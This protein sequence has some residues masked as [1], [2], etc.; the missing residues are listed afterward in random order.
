[1]LDVVFQPGNLLLGQLGGGLAKL[2]GKLAAGVGQRP[3]GLGGLSGGVG[4][5]PLPCPLAGLVHLLCGQ[6]G[7]LGGLLGLQ[8]RKLRAKA[9]PFPRAIAAGDWPSRCNWRSRASV[10]LILGGGLDLLV[11]FLLPLFQSRKIGLDRAEL[12]DQVGPIR[13]RG[14]W[15]GCRGLRCKSW[16]ICFC[17]AA[18]WP[19]WFCSISRAGI[20]HLAADGQPAG[21]VQGVGDEVG[22]QRVALAKLD[23]RPA[24]LPGARD[25]TAGQVQAAGRRRRADRR[26]PAAEGRGAR[27]S[28]CGGRLPTCDGPRPPDRGAIGQC[29][30]CSRR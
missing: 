1:M 22:G 3:P 15:P 29:S 16:A 19:I 25:P 27:G 6:R 4:R 17:A 10:V 11:Q 26:R 28:T 23:G 20:A 21:L 8:S 9:V 30:R 14:D 13:S 18:A 24:P 12:L 5:T 7:G 2:V